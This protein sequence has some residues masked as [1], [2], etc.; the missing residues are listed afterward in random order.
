VTIKAYRKRANKNAQ[1][2][3]FSFPKVVKQKVLGLERW[4]TS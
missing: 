3:D 4:L 2:S 1:Y